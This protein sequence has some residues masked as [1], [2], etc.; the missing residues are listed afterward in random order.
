[1]DIRCWML[2]PASKAGVTDVGT[3]GKT[4]YLEW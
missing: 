3:L 2:V 4:V 1:M